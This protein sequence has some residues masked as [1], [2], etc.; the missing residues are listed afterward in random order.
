MSKYDPLRLYLERLEVNSKTLS[1]DELEMILGTKLPNSAYNHKAW[2]ESNSKTHTQSN[3]W[4]F[5]GYKVVEINLGKSIK[6]VKNNLLGE[7]I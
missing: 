7:K 5:A 3:A 6:F 4:S 2:W 1:Y